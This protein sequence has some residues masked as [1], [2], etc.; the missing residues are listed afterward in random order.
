MHES[1]LSIK[2]VSQ[3]VADLLQTV[4]DDGF[5][6]PASTG[7]NPFEDVVTI[8]FKFEER[9]HNGRDTM[10]QIPKINQ[11]SFG[12]VENRLLNFHFHFDD[13]RL[14]VAVDDI[15]ALFDQLFDVWLLEDAFQLFVIGQNEQMVI[16]I[17]EFL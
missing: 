17:E 15:L 12:L 8:S 2:N 7:T 13:F 3:V 14:Q 4:F 9:D 6:N 10:R 16:V 1:L 11:I 5:W